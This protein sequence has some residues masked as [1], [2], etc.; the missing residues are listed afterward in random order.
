MP[1]LDHHIDECLDAIEAEPSIDNPTARPKTLINNVGQKLNA[2]CSATNDTYSVV[3]A[4]FIAMRLARA[5]GLNVTTVEMTRAAHKDVLLVER[6]DRTLMERGWT[7]HTMVSALTMLGSTEMMARYASHEDLAELIRHRFAEPKA[8][9]RELYSRISFNILCGNTDDR[10]R[11]HATFWDG[12]QLTLPPVY[13]IC[14]QGRTGNEAS[15][16]MLIKGEA[17]A[18]TLATC[19]AVAPDF[20]LK[21]S[22]SVALIQHQFAAIGAGWREACAEAA[23]IQVDGR[24]FAGRQFLNSF[25]LGGLSGQPALTGAFEAARNAL[26]VNAAA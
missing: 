2:K 17:H 23:L 18:S 12:R 4:E 1:G 10:A 21:E 19:L 20:R 3:K 11:K 8:T 9:L 7:R 14:P 6:F 16:A 24:L 25:A 5:A 26:Y 22:D 13:D 15:Q